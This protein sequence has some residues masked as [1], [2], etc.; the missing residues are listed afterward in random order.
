MLSRN[1]NRIITVIYVTCDLWRMERWRNG[2]TE[3]AQSPVILRTRAFYRDNFNSGPRHTEGY[4]TCY[5]RIKRNKRFNTAT[6]SGERVLRVFNP[7]DLFQLF[8][9]RRVVIIDLRKNR[10]R[11]SLFY[12]ASN[13]SIT[14]NEQIKYIVGAKLSLGPR[15]KIC[16]KPTRRRRL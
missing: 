5:K 9:Y 12:R 7:P 14:I 13:F 2:R 4:W 15:E 11:I 8:V 6:R 16:P 3:R 1:F 10:G